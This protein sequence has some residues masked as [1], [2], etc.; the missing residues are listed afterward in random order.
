MNNV[1]YENVSFVSRWNISFDTNNTNSFIKFIFLLLHQD[2]Y[3]T[4][5]TE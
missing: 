1:T 4:S 2:M 5:I 3:D